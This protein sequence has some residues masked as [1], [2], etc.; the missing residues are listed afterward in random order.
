[1]NWTLTPTIDDHE[2]G[3]RITPRCVIVWAE[4]AERR[5]NGFAAPR[6]SSLR[7][8]VVVHR[9]TGQRPPFRDSHRARTRSSIA[10]CRVARDLAPTRD[11]NPIDPVE[12][13]GIDIELPQKGIQ[14]AAMLEFLLHEVPQDVAD[15]E[16]VISTERPALGKSNRPVK[17]PQIG[18]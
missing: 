3:R 14:L 12:D 13:R 10:G 2:A 9:P 6:S 16:F 8:A 11:L 5:Q 4:I 1:M 7:T 17:V 15:R 18:R